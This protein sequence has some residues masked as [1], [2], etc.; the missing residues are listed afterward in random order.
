MVTNLFRLIFIIYGIVVLLPFVWLLYNTFKSNMEFNLNIW[1]LPSRLRWEN[2][3]LAFEK[4]NVGVY[5]INSVII[6]CIAVLLNVGLSAALSYVISRFRFWGRDFIYKLILAGLLMPRILTVI[7]YFFLMREMSLFNTRASVIIAYTF[8]GMPFAVFLLVAFFKT[9][10]QELEQAAMIDGC[11]YW[12]TFTLIMLPLARPGLITVS[13][14]NF[15]E[16]WSAYILPLTL[17]ADEV[18]KPVSLGLVEFSS[19]VGIRQDWGA[20][21]AACII[22]IL[23]ILLV[24]TIFQRK[25]VAGLTAGSLK[26]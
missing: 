24:Y 11:S 25:L 13:V 12:K 17:I 4:A 10:P 18:R 5:M 8:W 19:G 1:S 16:F 26:G 6:T 21:F 7:P 9:L 23:P 3:R 20:M 2:Y 14:F 22:C 15:L